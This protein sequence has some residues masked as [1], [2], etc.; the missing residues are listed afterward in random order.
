MATSLIPLIN[1]KS[2]EF[3]DITCVVLGVP[4]VGITSIEYGEDS[5]TENIYATGRFPV[6][7]G[8]GRVQT[9]AKIT[10]L[11]E[12]V[13]NI[14]SVAPTGRIYDIPEFDIIVTF[15]DASL[16]PVAHKIRNCRFKNN[17]ISSATGDT[18][19]PVELDLVVSHIEWQ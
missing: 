17:K 16:I 1:G 15:T 2:Y 9:N 10:M 3:A 11:M 14:V 19:I 4:I 7:R 18:S 6:S 13:N 12:E 8:V 5:E